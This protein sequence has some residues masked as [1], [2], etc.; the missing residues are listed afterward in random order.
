MSVKSYKAVVALRIT[1]NPKIAN[2][3]TGNLTDTTDIFLAAFALRI[4]KPFI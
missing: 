4:I 3:L 1:G 2:R